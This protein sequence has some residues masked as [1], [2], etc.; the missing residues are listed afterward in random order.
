MS[1]ANNG[2]LLTYNLLINFSDSFRHTYGEPVRHRN[3]GL[4]KHEKA[5]T[6]II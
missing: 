3:V 2:F 5:Y 1:L 6:M 4:L